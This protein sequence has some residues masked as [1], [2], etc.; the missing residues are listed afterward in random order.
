M[1]DS[2]QDPHLL[3]LVVY[4]PMLFHKTVIPTCRGTDIVLLL[5]LG[6]LVVSHLVHAGDAPVRKLVGLDPPSFKG[7]AIKQDNDQIVAI[8]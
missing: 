5:L 6:T 4:L 8:L 1:L 3:L 7:L 2:V